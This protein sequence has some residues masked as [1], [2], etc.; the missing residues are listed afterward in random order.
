MSERPPTLFLRTLGLEV[1]EI[2]RLLSTVVGSCVAVCLHD[3]G[4]GIGGMNHYLLPER[5]SGGRDEPLRYGRE[6][7]PLL[8]ERLLD[9]GASRGRMVA[10]LVGGARM[11]EM[12]PDLEGIPRANIRVARAVLQEEEIPVVAEHVGGSEG[13]RVWFATDS[14]VLQVELG[15]RTRFEL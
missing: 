12:G 8:L 4:A 3:P 11:L 9:L 6:A 2:P 13:R 10:K 15:D 1:S 5:P 7:I 14:G